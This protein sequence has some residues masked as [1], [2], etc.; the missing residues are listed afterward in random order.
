LDDFFDTVFNDVRDNTMAKLS[1]LAD[2]A[3]LLP[4]AH[5]AQEAPQAAPK[6]GYDGKAQTLRIITEKRANKVLTSLTGFQSNP[7]ELEAI[8]RDL[9][10]QCGAGGR[11]LDN[12]IELQGDHRAKAALYLAQK[13]FTIKQ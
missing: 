11:V 3:T 2:L 12:A 9:K 6:L 4:E 13:G 8:V 7:L 10:K 1:S 5:R